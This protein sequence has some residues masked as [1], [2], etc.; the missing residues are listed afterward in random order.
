[1]LG[2]LPS[3]KVGREKGAFLP[4]RDSYNCRE[5]VCDSYNC[6]EAVRNSSLSM[7]NLFFLKKK[8]VRI[9]TYILPLGHCNI[10]R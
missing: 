3:N 2:I 5:A 10:L 1:M 9:G 6:R 8:K 4:V 7:K